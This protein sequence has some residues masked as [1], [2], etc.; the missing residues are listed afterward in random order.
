M[1]IEIQVHGGMMEV[2]QGTASQYYPA[3]QVEVSHDGI[4]KVSIFTAYSGGNVRQRI[5][6]APYTDFT[7]QVEGLSAEAVAMNI[8]MLFG[9][10]QKSVLLQDQATPPVISH[11][12]NVTNQTT[13]SAATAI[14]DRTITLTST[15]G[16]VAGA[17]ITIYDATNI[18]YYQAHQIG[19][20]VGS[21]I[22]VDTP[23]DFA[24]PN[25]TNVAISS[26]NLAVNGSVTPVIFGVRVVETPDPLDIILDVTKINI[27]M[28]TDTQPNL[29]TFGDLT[30]LT[31]G[32]VL[33]SRNGT[34][35]NIFNAK[36][37]GELSIISSDITMYDAQNPQQGQFGVNVEISFAGQ[38]EMGVVIRLGQGEDLELIVSD[39]LLLLGSFEAMAEGHILQKLTHFH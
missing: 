33:R 10:A 19:A 4:S 27:I 12:K 32:I 6:I 35:Q 25:G 23:L 3:D 15:T 34:Y 16:A 18:R 17:D 5:A 8:A 26:H 11:F 36:T 14:D 22:T 21:V 29:A 2:I 31:N 13:L 20:A 37:N 1:A 7:G 39:D 30:A 9:G 24:F 38:H 28:E